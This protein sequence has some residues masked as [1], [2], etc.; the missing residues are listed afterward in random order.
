MFCENVG[1]AKCTDSDAPLTTWAARS[2]LSYGI[3]CSRPPSSAYCAVTEKRGIRSTINCNRREFPATRAHIRHSEDCSIHLRGQ[4]DIAHNRSP[5]FYIL[6]MERPGLVFAQ[7]QHL[8]RRLVYTRLVI[9]CYR[10][11]LFIGVFRV[12]S[13]SDFSEL[14]PRGRI[15]L[16]MSEFW[17]SRI[18]R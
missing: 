14:P 11:Y 3:A 8:V 7:S 1:L 17:T 2:C 10:R 15:W 4:K 18:L 5:Y 9:Y 6:R 12:E 13:V 16:D